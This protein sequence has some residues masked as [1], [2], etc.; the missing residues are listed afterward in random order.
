MNR[1]VCPVFVRVASLFNELKIVA[2]KQTGLTAFT[3]LELFQMLSSDLSVFDVLADAFG[4]AQL[5]T[6]EEGMPNSIS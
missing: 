6:L 4:R 2:S 1:P 3:P 5:G